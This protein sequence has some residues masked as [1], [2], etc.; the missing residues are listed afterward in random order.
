M[1]TASVE[2]RL[3]L[4]KVAEAAGLAPSAENTQPWRFIAHG[5]CLTICLDAT[6][7]LE[8]DVDGMLD[9]TSLGACLENAVIAFRQAGFEPRVTMRTR[10][11]LPAP[12]DRFVPVVD[13]EPGAACAADPLH[14]HLQNRCTS[15]RM[16]GKRA[17]AEAQLRALTGSISV[18]PAVRVDWITDRREIER[19]GALVGAA[20]RIRFEHEPFH[21]EFYRNVRFSASAARQSRDGL[22]VATLQLPWGV[23]TILRWMRFWQRIRVANRLGFSRSIE[24]HAR[25]ETCAS[26]AIGVL[27]VDSAASECFLEGGRALERL[28]LSATAAGLGLHPAAALPVFLAYAERTDGSM[29]PPRLWRRVQAMKASVDSCVPQLAGRTVQM[30][31]RLGYAAPASVRSL[32]RPLQEVLEV[33]ETV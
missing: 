12:E 31:F 20:N 10:E 1:A 6:R 3:D 32:R 19:L 30:V 33:N 15:R 17:V 13:L 26:G 5:D 9:L 27:S 25:Q 11:K 24:R 23:P 4:T 21:A 16:D 29:L 22:D 2:R 7:K 8:S 18:F 14:R 28:W